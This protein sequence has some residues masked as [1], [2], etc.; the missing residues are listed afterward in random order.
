MQSGNR[1]LIMLEFNELCPSL[2]DRFIADGRLPN[3]RKLRDSSVVYTTDAEEKAPYLEPWIQWVTVHT[4]TSYKEH[5]AF[6]LGDGHKVAFPRVWDLVGEA[7]HKVWICGSMNAAFRKP[8]DGYILPDPWSTGIEPYPLHEFDP[9]IQ[10]V[11]QNVHEHTR[12]KSVSNRNDQL[13]F[14]K[15]MM[16]HGM[17]L[18]TITAIVKQLMTETRGKFRW[19]RAAILDR[20]QWDVFQHYWQRHK[21]TF[22]TFFLNSTAHFQHLYWRNMDS[23]PFAVKPKPEEQQEYSEAIAFGYEQMD[24]IVGKCLALADPNTSVVLATG[25]SQQPFLKYEEVGGKV[26]FRPIDVD[27]FQKYVGIEGNPE[28]APVMAEQ[29]YL[30]FATDA[31]AEKATRQLL[32]LRWNETPVFLAR[33]KGREVFAGCAVHVNVPSD[34]VITNEKGETTRFFE[35]FYCC[36]V[37]KSGMH[38]P[39]GIFWVRQPGISARVHHEKV[40]LRQVAPT[41]LTLMGRP[42]PDY[43]S[44]PLEAVAPNVAAA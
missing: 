21:P 26:M 42:V 5:G 13:Q 29:F 1:R 19:K 20:L 24:V 12:E 4:G 8:I 40:P 7:G 14:M 43:M 23:E 33:Q 15:F 25:L 16:G 32:A 17:S 18:K 22:A 27:A 3:F 35:Q 37:V 38:H 34:A 44:P 31:E 28:F 10:F 36:N 41:L 2:M 9:Y 39:D 6:D 30:N 11:R